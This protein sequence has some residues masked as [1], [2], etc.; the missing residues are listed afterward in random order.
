M[1]AQ[2]LFVTVAADIRTIFTAPDRVTAEQYLGR[3]VQKYAKSASK[4]AAWIEA[5][6]SEGFTVFSFPK[7]HQR[8]L[9]TVKLLERANRELDRRTRVVSIFP[10]E[11][12]C[13]RLISALLM[14]LDDE[15][16]T[17]CVYLSMIA[18]GSSPS[19]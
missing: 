12:S 6:L 18:D 19:S 3:T 15:W 1:P 10:S 4:L 8:R 14:E 7:A 2:E 5:N 16:Q 11:S 9:R 13:M 17:G